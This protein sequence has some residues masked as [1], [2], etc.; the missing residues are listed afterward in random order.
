MY[1]I[2]IKQFLRYLFLSASEDKFEYNDKLDFELFLPIATRNRVTN[3]MF[4]GLKNISKENVP[5]KEIINRLQSDCML[6]GVKAFHQ[7]KAFKAIANEYEKENLKLTVIKGQILK[8]LYLKEDMRVMGDID[9][10]VPNND[11]LKG[12][13]ILVDKFGYIIEHEDKDELCALNSQKVCVELH[14]HLVT[15]LSN[16]QKYFDKTYLSHIIKKENYYVLDKDYHFIYMMDHIYKHFIDGGLGLKYILDFAL[17]IKKY[18]DV[19]KNTIAE[20][21][22]LGLANLTLGFLQVCNDCIDLD[23]SVQLNLFNK[24]INEQA[25]QKLII[26]MLK[27]GEYGTVESRVNAKNVQGTFFKRMKR[28]LFPM[29]VRPGKNKLAEFILYPF[30][31]VCYWFSFLF[32]NLG[33]VFLVLK[34]RSNIDLKEKIDLKNMFDELK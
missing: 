30:R 14:Q 3:I 22:K 26:L 8:S 12:R 18:P 17:Y 29:V 33:Y 19:I 13:K 5:S 24:R 6:Y 25:L 2:K 4:Y 34:K 1:D 28:R 20:L 21:K 32:K 9:F 10:I 11:Y 16:N 23:V 31:L 15:E 27:N 7:E